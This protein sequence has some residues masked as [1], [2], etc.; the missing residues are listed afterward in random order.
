[1]KLHMLAISFLITVQA[2]AA[3]SAAPAEL[4]RENNFD[5]QWRFLKADA[6]G[7]EAAALD[8]SAWRTVD[9]P[10]DWSIE[11]LP[12]QQAAGRPQ[13]ALP[14]ASAASSPAPSEFHR[15]GRRRSRAG[16]HQF[17]VV[18]PFSPASPGG[19]ATGYTLGGTGWYRKH[20][21]LPPQTA[22]KRVSI[23][24]DGVY[25]DSDVWLNGHHLGNH[26]Y[27]YTAF[28]YDLT[29]H[30]N[31][32]GQDNVLAVR[33]A[34]CRSKQPAGIPVPASTGALCCG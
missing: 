26:P 18:G 12:D 3:L 22:G 25:M 11:D 27:G 20:F 16:E 32:S 19:R 13:S 9:L 23:Q 34:Q 21:T 28:A 5:L 31:P 10:H 1:M 2:F 17:P 24:F 30:L 8:D 6:P 4:K 29:D 14:A 33:S 15:A 7:A